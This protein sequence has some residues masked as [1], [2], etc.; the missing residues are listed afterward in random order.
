MLTVSEVWWGAVI[1]AGLRSMKSPDFD[2][3]VLKAEDV[4]GYC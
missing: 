4:I 3:D 1:I 2:D